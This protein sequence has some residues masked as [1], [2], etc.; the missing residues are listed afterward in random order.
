MLRKNVGRINHVAI[1]V[2][3]E[4]LTAAVE[5][6]SELLDIKFEG[7]LEST[8]AGITYYLDWDSGMEVYA[9]NDRMLAAD[10]FKFL[11]EHGEGL[12]RL[13]FG[14]ADIGEA[15]E[16]A[17]ALGHELP[18]YGSAFNMNPKWRDRFEKMDEALLREPVHG[19]RIAFSQMEPKDSELE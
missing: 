13:I 17:H 5:D 9:P 1:C 15:V 16:R 8:T 7:P 11:E 6:F 19:V 2:L 10:R 3:P 4:N 14:V 18:H 12:F